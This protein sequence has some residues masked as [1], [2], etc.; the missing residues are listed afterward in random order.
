MK[1]GFTLI[2]LLAVIV[3]LSIILLIAVPIVLRVIKDSKKSTLKD[4]LELYGRA[5]EQGV[6]NYFLKNPEED[7]VTMEELEKGEYIQYKG[8]KVQQKKNYIGY[9]ADVDG[10]GNADGIIYADLAHSKSGNFY[11]KDTNW[12]QNDGEYSY[13]VLDDLK[14]Y[15]I[16][17]NKYTGENA[18]FG[19]KEII[20]LKPGSSGKSRFYVMALTDFRTGSFEA[21]SGYTEG[22][23]YW[24]YNAYGKMDTSDTSPEFGT[25]YT[26]TG[27][28]IRI[29]NAGE[30]GKYNAGQNEYD[31]W[32]KIQSEYAK[33]W[34]IPSK[35]EWAAFA[36]Y[37]AHSEENPLTNNCPTTSCGGNG[38][39]DDIY[40]LSDYYWSS[41]QRHTGSAWYAD[42]RSGY[43]YSDTVT[44]SYYVRLGVTF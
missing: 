10:D 30:S 43:M 37:L 33:G 9:Y 12:G 2:E 15:T 11:N 14:E 32:G 26:N 42:F 8:T 18:K 19:E 28:I 4:S 41:S 29:W 21:G 36:D 31:I 7:E 22:T 17:E 25:G 3:I 44:Y 27:N 23:Y 13:E 34:Y 1:K 38:N 35:E 39:Y 40:G 6:A 24:Y 16:S 20:A 5:V